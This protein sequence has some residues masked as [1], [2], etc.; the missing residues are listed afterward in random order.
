VT[1]GARTFVSVMG[2]F[3]AFD[4]ARELDRRGRLAG[5]FTSY[6]QSTLAR[7]GL[8]PRHARTLPWVEVGARALRRASQRRAAALEPW[9]ATQFDRWV[10]LELHDDADAFIGW[11]GMCMASLRRAKDLGLATF[12]ERGSAHIEAQSALLAEE[13]E[14]QGGRPV[15]PHPNTIARELAEYELA[16]RIV[17]PSQFAVRTFVERGVPREKLV[18]NPYGVD[19]SAFTP[20]TAPAPGFRVLFCG[21]A[22]VQK[23]IAYL[24][25]AFERFHAPDAELWIQGAVEDD[26]RELAQRTTDSRVRWLGHRAQAELPTV[27]REAHVLVLPSIQDGYGL[28]VPQALASG[29]P[30]IVS[31]NTGTADLVRHGID[32]FVVPIRSSESILAHLEELYADRERLTAFGRAAR[33]SVE[34]GHGWADYGRRAA[35]IVDAAVVAH[36]PRGPRGLIRGDGSFREAV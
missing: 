30:C 10:A 34:T 20:P 8:D 5:L 18:V 4:L 27:Y 6:P 14:R 28:V 36:S 1:S 29:L 23:G 7:F 21:R 24:L 16:D 25:E 35:D 3:H 22:S 17:V 11:S 9:F 19:L 32:G 26:V 33:E 12:V 2:R 15:L 13:F 31:A